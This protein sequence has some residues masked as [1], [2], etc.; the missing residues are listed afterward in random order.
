M[1]AN[2]SYPK[3]EIEFYSRQYSIGQLVENY[4]FPNLM[5]YYLFGMNSL[6]KMDTIIEE[7]LFDF[8]GRTQFQVEQD[9]SYF[10]VRTHVIKTAME[11]LTACSVFLCSDS[12]MVT[13]NN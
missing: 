13:Y 11:K 8:V 6:K 9:K 5:A 1:K 4:D 7:G 3:S 10:L 2:Y 12:V